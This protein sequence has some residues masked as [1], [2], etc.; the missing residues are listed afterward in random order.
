MEAI[1]SSSHMGFSLWQF[2]LPKSASQW[3]ESADKMGVTILCNVIM[4]VKIS[5]SLPYFTGKKQVRVP[6]YI[7]GKKMTHGSD[8]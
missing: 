4:E 6:A 1:V 3:K 2:T 7:Q 5:V 8:N